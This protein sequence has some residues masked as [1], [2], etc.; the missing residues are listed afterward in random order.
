MVETP[1]G[2]LGRRAELVLQEA[3]HPLRARAQLLIDL[4]Q[5][6]HV[7]LH[8]QADLPPE[9]AEREHPVVE[10]GLDGVHRLLE[11]VHLPPLLLGVHALALR[12]LVGVAGLQHEV[13]QS[14]LRVRDRLHVL[15]V[16]VGIRRFGFFQILHRHLALLALLPP[17]LP[18][19]RASRHL[20]ATRGP[21]QR[22]GLSVQLERTPQRSGC[23]QHAWRSWIPDPSA[24]VVALLVGREDQLVQPGQARLQLLRHRGTTEGS[25]A[26]RRAEPQDLDALKVEAGEVVVSKLLH[27][28]LVELDRP[29]E[30]ELDLLDLGL[31][32]LG[33]EGDVLL[34][35]GQL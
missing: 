31:H 13:A 23:T 25:H 12:H 10:L 6:R 2:E 32:V 11:E 28:P 8:L 27:A 14:G 1:L 29:R 9:V 18:L 17:Q 3:L 7:A 30:L 22:T 21:L 24:L 20:A 15:G 5:R 26:V 35:D 16:L 33:Q 4:L 34:I 19:L